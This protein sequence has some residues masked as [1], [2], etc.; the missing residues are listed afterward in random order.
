[1]DTGLIKGLSFAEYSDLTGVNCSLLKL[2]HRYSLAHVKAEIDGLI[3]RE[4]D[5]LDF[6]QSFHS[7]LLRGESN[8]VVRP[9][10]YP[11]GKAHPK[12]KAKE[13]SEGDPLPWNGNAGCC[14]DWESE[15]INAQVHDLAEVEAM[16]G[17]VESVKSDSHLSVMLSGDCE[18][19]ATGEKNGVLLKCLIDLLPSDPKAPVIDF[20]KARSCEPGKFVKDANDLGYFMQAAFT[21]DVLNLCGQGR[22][23]FWFVAVE[24]NPPYALSI[25]GFDDIPGSLLRVGRRRYKAALAKLLMARES[26]CWPGYGLNTA[27]DFAPVWLKDELEATL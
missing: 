8:Y 1:M 22:S 3:T 4:S 25:I 9:E 10:T 14:K 18:I 12:V 5:A 7:L 11:A 13:I 27:E 23:S 17:M 20:K 2:V 19:A 26:N 15:H 6:G 24:D 16:Q 21:L